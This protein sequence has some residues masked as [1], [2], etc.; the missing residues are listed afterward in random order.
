MRKR[1]AGAITK[2]FRSLRVRNFRLF[3][4]GQL[5]SQ[6][7]TW[8]TTIAL[9]L[10][11]L[12]LTKSG[13]AIGGLVACQFGPVLLLGAWGGLIADRSDKRRLLIT[14]QTLEMGQSFTLAVLAFTH[15]P[16]VAFYI[17]ALAGGFMLAFDN[18]AR[19]SFVPEMVP[20]EQ[21]HNAVTLNSALMTSSR[22]FG[23]ALAGL[24]VV[25]VGFAW[26]FTVDGASYL[27]V[28]AGLL[29]MRKSELRQPERTVKAKGQVREGLRYIRTVRELWIPLMMATVVGTLTFNF[30]VVLPL[31]AERTLHGTDG[32]FTILYSVLSVGSF[33]GA[34]VAAH[35]SSIGV[36]DVVIACFG[37]GVA[38]LVFAAAPT[39]AVAFP[40]ALFVGFCSIAFMTAATAIVQVRADPSMRGRVLALQAIV[41]IGTTPIGGPVMGA[42][43]DAFGARVGLIIGGLAALA[44]ATWGYAVGPRADRRLRLSPDA[45]V[46]TAEAA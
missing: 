23:P 6:I 8:L 21:V 9:T 13:F 7:G 42:V 26:C 33:S 40:L 11:V 14:T 32:T 27:A 25:T 34:L 44:S 1:V 19:R 46:D 20:E 30:S 38:M 15:P 29:M 10:L 31:F 5:I 24:L 2:T 41:I 4:V 36:R 12:H 17:T 16:L 3:F 28:I 22:I 43:C 45:S 35:R 39:I 18:P 37:F